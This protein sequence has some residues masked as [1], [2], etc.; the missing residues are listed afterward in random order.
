[1]LT[2]TPASYGQKYT[3]ATGTGSLELAR[4]TDH[5]TAANGV[6]L[7]GEKDIFGKPFNSAAMATA[8]AT[9]SS[10]SG[11][12][13]NGS[14]WSGSS[15]SGSSWSGSSWSGTSWSGN[16]WSGGSWLGASWD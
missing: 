16:S 15:W 5:L 13:W 10:R 7:S 12:T 14:S 3:N 9:G 6:V 4:G 2:K 8:E 1:M 11:G